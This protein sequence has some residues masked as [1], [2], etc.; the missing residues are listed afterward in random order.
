MPQLDR[1]RGGWGHEHLAATLRADIH[2]AIIAGTADRRDA[3]HA[4]EAHVAGLA[5]T[6][7]VY[8]AE[9]SAPHLQCGRRSDGRT[10]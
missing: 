6:K 9:N 5:S 4:I 3:T 10:A 2:D 7:A 8:P 1:V